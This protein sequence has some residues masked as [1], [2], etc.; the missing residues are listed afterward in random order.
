M[1]F[2]LF[3]HKKIENEQYLINYPITILLI[4]AL[5]QKKTN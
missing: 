1:P 3:L 2:I 5:K 4:C